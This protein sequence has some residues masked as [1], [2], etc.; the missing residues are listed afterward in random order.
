MLLSLE[1]LLISHIS[2]CTAV[3][4]AKSKIAWMKNFGVDKHDWPAV[5]TSTHSYT[6]GMN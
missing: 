3:H 2:L 5:L 4:T 6:F 1:E